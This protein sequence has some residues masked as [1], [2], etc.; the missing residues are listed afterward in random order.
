MKR[1]ED[2]YRPKD[3]RELDIRGLEVGGSGSTGRRNHVKKSAHA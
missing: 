3:D 2:R 1:A